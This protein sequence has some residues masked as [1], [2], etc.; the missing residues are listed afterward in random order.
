[1]DTRANSEVR[2]NENFGVLKLSLAPDGYRWEFLATDGTSTWTV[3]SGADACHG[4]P[5]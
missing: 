1:M 2:Y 4:R 5:E 3:D